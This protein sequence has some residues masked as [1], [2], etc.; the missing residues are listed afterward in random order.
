MAVLSINRRLQETMKDLCC[1]YCK[2]IPLSQ[3][4]IRHGLITI[5]WRQ[6]LPVIEWRHSCC[7]WLEILRIMRSA[8]KI[9]EV[10]VRNHKG[11]LLIYMLLQGTSTNVVI[12]CA[13]LACLYMASNWKFPGL[14][15]NGVLLLNDKCVSAL[16]DGNAIT[17]P[18]FSYVWGHQAVTI[19]F[20][21]WTSIL[22]I[23]GF[24]MM[25][26]LCCCFSFILLQL[27]H[28]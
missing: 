26:W 14:L 3:E 21:C 20:Q 28:T 19:F 1:C 16:C 5:T 24:G 7:L 9:V 12:Y 4:L 2:Y 17:F 8:G 27:I 25:M 6:T 22:N 23:I 11:V 15:Q 13:I 18:M 10:M